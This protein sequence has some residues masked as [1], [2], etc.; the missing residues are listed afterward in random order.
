MTN[1]DKINA[2]LKIF[3]AFLIPPWISGLIYYFCSWSAPI[4]EGRIE[5]YLNYLKTYQIYPLEQIFNFT[6]LYYFPFVIFGIPILLMCKWKNMYDFKTHILIWA[7]IGIS[8]GLSFCGLFWSPDEKETFRDTYWVLYSIPISISLG[9]IV[10]W[11][12]GI[13]KVN[14]RK[15]VS[16]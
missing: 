7:F 1:F 5:G 12:F 15:T 8:L 16:L 6:I 4:I 14:Y 10:F 11:F 3:L 2:S 9:G 13:R